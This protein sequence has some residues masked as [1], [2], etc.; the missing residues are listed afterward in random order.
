M[1]QGASGCGKTTLV[2]KLEKLNSNFRIFK[3]KMAVALKNIPFAPFISLVNSFSDFRKFNYNFSIKDI[4]ELETNKKIFFENIKSVVKNILEKDRLMIILEDFQY[5]DSDSLEVLLFLLNSTDII[6][7][8]LMIILT[9]DYNVNYD[10][11]YFRELLK[12]SFFYTIEL[13]SLDMN[14]TISLINGILNID[15]NISDKFY[16]KI[17]FYSNGNPLFIKSL[18]RNLIDYGVI[19]RDDEEIKIK[20]DRFYNFDFSD[21]IY[22]L[23]VNKIDFLDE[24]TK[25]ILEIASVITP[26]T[27]FDFNI[28]KKVAKV[29]SYDFEFLP[30]LK[31]AIKDGLIEQQDNVYFNFTHIK[32]KEVFYNS[33]DEQYRIELHNIIAGV[34]EDNK[35]D[36]YSVCYHYNRSGNIQKCIKYNRLCY[37]ESVK[38]FSLF[39]ASYFISRIIEIKISNSIIDDYFFE[40]VLIFSKLSYSSGKLREAIEFLNKALDF[41]NKPELLIEL[42]IEKGNCFYFLNEMSTA[43]S[44]YNKAFEI[45]D[46]NNIKINT[47]YPYAIIG[48]FYYFTYQL[49]KAYFFLNNALNYIE[50]ANTETKIRIYGIKVAVTLLM[51]RFE[52]SY[53]SLV[54]LESIFD[55]TSN[56]FLLSLAY[57]YASVYYVFSRKDMDK[58]IFYSITAEK[59]AR[60]V[61]N[62]L[63]IYAS[64]APRAIGYFY[65]KEYE[66]ALDCIEKGLLLSKKYNI[67]IGLNIFYAYKVNTLLYQSKFE[68]AYELATEIIENRVVPENMCK[69]FFMRARAIYFYV[70]S[71]IE[72]ALKELDKAIEIAKSNSINTFLIVLLNDKKFILE[73]SRGDFKD[74][75]KLLNTE[76]SNDNYLPFFEESSILHMNILNIKTLKKD[77]SLKN[78]LTDK[79]ILSIFVAINNLYKW[80]NYDSEF[81]IISILEKILELTDSY[82]IALRIN[83]K[84]YEKSTKEKEITIDLIPHAFLLRVS[85]SKNYIS[86]NVILKNTKKIE[87][88]VFFPI[89]MSNTNIGFIIIVFKQ[90]R[91]EDYLEKISIIIDTLSFYFFNASNKFVKKSDIFQKYEITDR[92]K[93]IVEYVLKGF[94]NKEIAKK[95]HISEMTVKIHIHNIFDKIGVRNRVELVKMFN[96]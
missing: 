60:E 77:K 41:T 95:L 47:S 73:K 6:D 34:L 9:S 81:I 55:L 75:L 3:Y 38:N 29:L 30:A 61:E 49:D 96:G 83:D 10:S 4:N 19:Y 32:I 21:D 68:E 64:Y 36:I 23:I 58:G 8:K 89:I 74:I 39:N 46:K 66:K 72:D 82:Y 26:E 2:N 12:L 94:K 43:I 69:I 16:E 25:K 86:T 52:E 45:A 54:K 85:S 93:E 37:E 20:F 88:V 80:N 51:G 11:V 87:N 1:I 57:H 67:Y 35:N 5:I 18:I 53:E 15:Y 65:K 14:E 7:K 44:F 50:T 56:P 24:K 31:E 13:S 92:E 48:S 17:F 63:I 90:K 62:E 84:D 27:I 28:L 22:Q 78:V 70:N 40:E 33:L 42:F 71:N 79:N 76:Y 91:D 59:V